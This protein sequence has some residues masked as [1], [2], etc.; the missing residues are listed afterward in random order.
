MET[1]TQ[2][3]KP[4]INETQPSQIQENTLKI[5]DLDIEILPT[6][7]EI[8]RCVEKDPSDNRNVSQECSQKILELKRRFDTARSQIKQL[9]GIDFNKEEQLQKRELL[10]SQLKQKQELIAKYKNKQF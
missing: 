4:I 9:S 7:Y 8:I 1:Q 6:I 2:D 10:R 3:I 5:A